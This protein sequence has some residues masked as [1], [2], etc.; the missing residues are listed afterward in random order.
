[1][2][3]PS[4]T[5]RE[6]WRSLEELAESPE[7]RQHLEKEFPSATGALEDPVSRRSFLGLMGAAVAMSGLVGCRR[8]LTK[9]YG[10]GLPR[11]SSRSR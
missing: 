1:M 10:K 6:A 11:H 9:V 5:R 8:P 2:I 4:K 7:F 3:R